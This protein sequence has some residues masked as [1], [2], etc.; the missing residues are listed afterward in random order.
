M[1]WGVATFVRRGICAG[2][3]VLSSGM[4][5]SYYLILWQ[6]IQALIRRLDGEPAGGPQPFPKD[7]GNG[8]TPPA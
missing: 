5:V 4:T 6:G 2:L 1:G 3:R 7:K 8:L